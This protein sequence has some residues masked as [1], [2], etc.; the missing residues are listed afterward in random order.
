[1]DREK[2]RVYEYLRLIGR[3][4]ALLV[5]ADII[6]GEPPSQVP[7]SGTQLPQLATPVFSKLEDKVKKERN[8]KP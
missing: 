1:V 6:S 7:V 3:E 8:Y 5:V 4:V 2:E